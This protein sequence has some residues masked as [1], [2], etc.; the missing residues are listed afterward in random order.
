MMISRV[1]PLHDK[2]VSTTTA[3]DNAEHKMST[4]DSKRKVLV[5][6]LASEFTW[7]TNL[8]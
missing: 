3:V 8:D 2:V 7:F 6:P 1:K 5:Q 4:L